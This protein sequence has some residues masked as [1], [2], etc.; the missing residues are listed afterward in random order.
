MDCSLEALNTPS[1]GLETWSSCRRKRSV[2]IPVGGALW[3]AL[4][5]PTRLA[6][7]FRS[8]EVSERK[9]AHDVLRRQGIA[10]ALGCDLPAKFVGPDGAAESEA[11]SRS[12]YRRLASSGRRSGEQALLTFCDALGTG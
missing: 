9:L 4:N 6:S 7:R 1:C 10:R 11:A 5:W 2:P 12:R 3:K 8:R